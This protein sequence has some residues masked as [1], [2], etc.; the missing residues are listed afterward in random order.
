MLELAL[1]A[2]QSSADLAET[3]SATGL[4]EKH[5]DKLAPAGKS[6]GSVVGTMLFHGL[7]EFNTGK[8]YGERVEATGRRC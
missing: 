7:F 1:A 4:A 2:G 5:G 6:L 3:M 8:Q